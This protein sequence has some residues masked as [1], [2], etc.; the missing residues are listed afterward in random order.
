MTS[1]GSRPSGAL[2]TLD[3][4][5]A[6]SWTVCGVQSGLRLSQQMCCAVA[7]PCFL[8]PADTEEL[9]HSRHV[10]LCPSVLGEYNANSLSGRILP[11]FLHF[12]RLC[13][14]SATFAVCAF[15][16]MDSAF[17]HPST[18][19]LDDCPG[20]CATLLVN[21]VSCMGLIV[22]VISRRSRS[23]GDTRTRAETLPLG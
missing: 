20:H 13:T 6:M 3:V 16:C 22:D 4:V 8:F 9:K 5:A 19:G 2:T 10:F 23:K 17:A 1:R 14:A 18:T 21:V 12:L 7:L 15:A 11:H